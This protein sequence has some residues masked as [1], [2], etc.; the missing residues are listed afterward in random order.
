MARPDQSLALERPL[1]AVGFVLAG[2][3]LGHACQQ[4][5]GAFNDDAFFWLVFA[6]CACFAGLLVPR[7]DAI[8]R[9]ARAALPLV[10]L[11]AVAC[12]AGDLLTMS[13]AIYIHGANA[14]LL[15][16]FFMGAA[17]SVV[18]AATA[19]VSKPPLGR[20]HV[21]ALVASYVA[22]GWWVLRASPNP[23]IDVF[24][25]Q[26]D[27]VAALMHGTNPYA[28]TFP[29]IYGNGVYYGPGMIANG[30]VLFGYV[31][32]PLTLL[33]VLPGTW[34]F[35]DTRFA[36]LFAIALVALSL[37]AGRT[38][39][40]IGLAAAALLVL[41]PRGYFVLEQSWTEPLVLVTLALVVWSAKHRPRLLPYAVGLF[42]ASKQY[43]VIAA[44]V[45]LL[46][47]WGMPWRDAAAFIGK[48]ALTG[49]VVTLPFVLWSPRDF[50][51]SVVELQFYQPFRDD[52]LSVLAWYK[53]TH[54]VE[55]PVW[56]AFAG[57]IAGSALA[58]LRLPRN[59]AGFAGG[60]A[61][62]LF[63]FIAFNKQAFCNYY[64]LVSG[65][66]FLAAGA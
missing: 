45:G 5:N 42:F 28:I 32:F 8:D 9:A 33:M 19:C 55:P 57:A 43:A 39:G 22:L 65:A 10:L 12:E 52:A 61:V 6:L 7:F 29:N 25:F 31:Y 13:P 36:Q 44:P 66:L 17:A 35:G 47:I 59:A 51:H 37:G 14:K 27:G 62:A 20:A 21:Y 41:L 49:I 48:V 3:A 38:K 1:A 11:A 2:T 54:H 64:F 53:R 23:W 63:L 26:R 16:P 50:Y 60:V 18:L 4:N 40:T 46:L 56:L 15:Q 34:I 58:L 30:R 24:V